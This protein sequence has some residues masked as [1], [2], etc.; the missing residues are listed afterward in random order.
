MEYLLRY[1]TMEQLD[2]NTLDGDIYCPFI[3]E[4]DN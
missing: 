4:H 1:Q 2:N 3:T